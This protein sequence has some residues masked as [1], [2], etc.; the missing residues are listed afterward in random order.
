MYLGMSMINESEKILE[1]F[2][3]FVDRFDGEIAHVTLKIDEEVFIGEYLTKEL[4]EKVL[5]SI[6]DLSVGLLKKKIK[7]Y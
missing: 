6:V 4:K 2:E 7:S 1:E 3:G 5:K